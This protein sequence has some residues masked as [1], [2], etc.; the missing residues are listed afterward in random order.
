ME[1][2]IPSPLLL[3]KL[4]SCPWIEWTVYSGRR[5]LR[6]NLANFHGTRLFLGR[7]R[8]RGGGRN[9]LVLGD[10]T[11]ETLLQVVALA[12]L[13][14]VTPLAR[15]LHLGATRLRLVTAP[16]KNTRSVHKLCT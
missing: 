5:L 9:L 3:S 16:R 14:L 15:L 10:A 11:A 1:S 4:P 13:A 2:L 12:R 6:R 8:G 7:R